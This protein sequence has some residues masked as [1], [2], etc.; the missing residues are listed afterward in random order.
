MS[1]PNPERNVRAK[2]LLAGASYITA[3][4]AGLAIYGAAH[5]DTLKGVAALL[6]ARI[7]DIGDGWWARH[8]N[9][10]SDAGAI[11]D[12]AVDKGTIALVAVN[13][14]QKEAIPRPV[15]AIIGAKSIASVGLTAMMAHNHPDE[16]FRP[17][18]AGKLS[19]VADS[20]AFIAYAT[21]EALKAEKPEL[22]TQQLIA[23][24]IGDAALATTIVTGAA[25]L[26][27]YAKRALS[28]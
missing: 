24:K 5:I 26:T 23:R 6:A 25:A 2:D 8:F 21:A 9:Q 7:G 15:I 16:S 11:F 13:A 10:E 27:Q 3:A 1:S 18:K 14:W 12:T 20:V 22:I 17:T 4:S 28:T 19:M